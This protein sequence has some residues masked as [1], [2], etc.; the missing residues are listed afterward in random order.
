MKVSVALCT[1]NGA[2]HL[3]VQLTSILRQTTRPDEIILCDD[4]SEDET[5]AIAQQFAEQSGIV[6]IVHRNPTRLGSVVNFEQ[7]IA[8]CSGD[9]ILLCDQ[10]DE[11]H[12]DRVERTVRALATAHAGYIVGDAD[13]MD[14][15]GQS[16]DER[17]WG[18][19]D[20]TESDR[21]RFNR[22]ESQGCLLMRQP[23]VTGATMAFRAE[24]RALF[25]PI[26]KRI[27]PKFHHD[28]WIAL[29]LTMHG[30]YGHALAEP[31]IRYRIH[32]NQQV[33]LRGRKSLFGLWLRRIGRRLKPLRQR[34]LYRRILTP[35]KQ[36]CP[37]EYRRQ[38]GR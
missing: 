7:A 26:P 17:L 13:L 30:H 16:L 31:L 29:S 6:M 22:C 21:E 33:G 10:D 12:P 14:D 27:Q 36:S 23:F 34:A 28:R 5:I 25:L 11:W 18:K 35:F 38:F 3:A 4:G 24:L 37:E 15:D 2:R 9:I 32:G 20:F 1:F 8:L 19:V